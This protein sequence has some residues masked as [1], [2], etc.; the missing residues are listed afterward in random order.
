[1][2]PSPDRFESITEFSVDGVEGTLGC[3]TRLGL[4]FVSR[5]RG[6]HLLVLIGPWPPFGRPGKALS[7]LRSLRAKDE[8][9]G[10]DDKSIDAIYVWPPNEGD[11]KGPRIEIF[12]TNGD[13]LTISCKGMER[14]P[15]RF[16][17]TR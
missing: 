3:I 14:S 8:H 1:M 13:I 16:E 11:P 17:P 9:P 4:A 2:D 6:R 7:K 12:T 15:D 5:T 10:Q